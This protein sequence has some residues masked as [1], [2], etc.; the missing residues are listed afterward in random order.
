M[1]SK[2]PKRGSKFKSKLIIEN[3]LILEEKL[4]KLYFFHG[5]DVFTISDITNVNVDRSEYD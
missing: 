3:L 4:L 5:S 1:V 2:Q